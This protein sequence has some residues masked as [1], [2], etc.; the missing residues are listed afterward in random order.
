MYELGS[1]SIAS[2][3]LIASTAKTFEDG[4]GGRID[5]SHPTTS[6]PTKA[7]AG[8]NEDLRGFNE[9]DRNSGM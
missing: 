5:G 2:W 6:S 9:N 7:S 3:D 1:P 4:S 8:T